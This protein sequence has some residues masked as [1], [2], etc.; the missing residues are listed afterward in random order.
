MR[1]ALF[2]YR[3]GDGIWEEKRNNLKSFLYA[4]SVVSHK[5][6]TQNNQQKIGMYLTAMKNVN[7][8]ENL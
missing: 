3:L 8:A 2:D 7:A 1:L 5:S 4:R 6:Q